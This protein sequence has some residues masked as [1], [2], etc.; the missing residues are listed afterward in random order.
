M[1]WKKRIRRHTADRLICAITA[2]SFIC[3]ANA[4]TLDGYVINGPDL[5]GFMSVINKKYYCISYQIEQAAKLNPKSRK[6]VWNYLI[7]NDLANVPNKVIR[8]IEELSRDY[9]VPLK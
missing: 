9:N 5:N 7:R 2:I 6:I 1:W 3:P 4:L 8:D